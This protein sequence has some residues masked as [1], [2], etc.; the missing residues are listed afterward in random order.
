MKSTIYTIKDL[1]VAAYLSYKKI[2]M[3]APWDSS[4]RCWSFDNTDGSCESLELEVRNGDAVVSIL[5]YET[6]R[7][8]VLSMVK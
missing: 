6:A 1:P 4:T 2:K 7:K 8:N 3:V 5:E